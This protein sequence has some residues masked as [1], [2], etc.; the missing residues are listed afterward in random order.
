[1]VD[2]GEGEVI[3]GRATP[4]LIIYNRVTHDVQLKTGMFGGVKK[5]NIRTDDNFY[6]GIIG[7]GP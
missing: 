5:V 2:T 4:L 3:S 1:M 7:Q 6:G